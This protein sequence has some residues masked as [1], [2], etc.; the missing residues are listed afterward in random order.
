MPTFSDMSR[1]LC[2]S[3]AE[4]LTNMNREAANIIY[5]SNKEIRTCSRH[6]M[7]PTSVVSRII[8]SGGWQ[9]MLTMDA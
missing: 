7:T 4:P 8:T 5:R 6:E 2:S 9:D 3:A 1:V